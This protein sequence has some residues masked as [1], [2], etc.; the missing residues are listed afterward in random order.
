LTDAMRKRK[1]KKRKERKES[2]KMNLT[3]AGLGGSAMI[4]YYVQLNAGSQMQ[5]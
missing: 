3:K 2:G 1:K 4:V 5:C